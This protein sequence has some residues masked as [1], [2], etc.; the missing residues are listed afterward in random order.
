MTANHFHS[1]REHSALKEY[2]EKT[3]YL[4]QPNLI[5]LVSSK[6]QWFLAEYDNLRQIS[7][8]S[9][10]LSYR[11]LGEPF[12]QYAMLEAK[13]LINYDADIELSMTDA[14]KLVNLGVKASNELLTNKAFLKAASKL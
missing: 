8:T 12:D 14:A 4:V 10:E 2:P 11:N 9:M 6:A 5:D 1:Y 13:D 7:E 3:L